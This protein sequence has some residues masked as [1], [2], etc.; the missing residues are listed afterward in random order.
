M[1]IPV[2]SE[3]SVVLSPG[4]FQSKSIRII[5]A[6]ALIP[7]TGRVILANDTTMTLLSVLRS[8]EGSLVRHTGFFL[9]TLGHYVTLVIF[10]MTQV[11]QGH[12]PFTLDIS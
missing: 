11:I 3:G 12:P 6:V 5:L 9:P 10:V 8:R 1:L 2:S 7:V 4:Q